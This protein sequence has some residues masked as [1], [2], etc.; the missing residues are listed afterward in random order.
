MDFNIYLT[1]GELGIF[2]FF[3]QGR[4][5][6]DDEDSDVWHRG[7]GAGLWLTPFN[8]LVVTGSM[9]FSDEGRLFDLSI[10]FQY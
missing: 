9:G 1:R 10:G 4:V 7:Y 5:W 3:D 2:G 6:A 8:L